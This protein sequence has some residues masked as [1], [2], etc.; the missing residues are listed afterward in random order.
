MDELHMNLGELKSLFAKYAKDPY[1]QYFTE[2][3]VTTLLN[4]ALYQLQRR[5]LK[6]HAARYSVCTSTTLV[7]GQ[8]Q[9]ALP[10]DFLALF[11]LWIDL[12]QPNPQPA[13]LPLTWIPLSKRHEFINTN[14]T[15][16]HFFMLK[17]SVNVMVPPDTALELEMIYAPRVALMVSNSDIPDAPEEYHEYL[18]LLSADTAY[19][20]DDRASEL[21]DRRLK[22][23]ED[24]LTANEQ[25]IQSQPRY[26]IEVS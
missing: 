15:P 5:L 6:T 8:S 19:M 7:V 1:Y 25:R 26:I 18:P 9:Y 4:N 11:D 3:E 12:D 17:D 10:S 21:V 22:Y 13:T 16:T 23:F 14:G 20:I 24:L 2:T